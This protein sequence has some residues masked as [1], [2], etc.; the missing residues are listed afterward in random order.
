MCHRS[1][2]IKQ[3]EHECSATKICISFC[4]LLR[5]DGGKADSHSRNE[6]LYVGKRLYTV[7]KRSF[8]W[9]QTEVSSLH[10]KICLM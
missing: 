1:L 8:H 5:K 6:R 10:F 4:V 2:D 7:Q 9:E 3:N